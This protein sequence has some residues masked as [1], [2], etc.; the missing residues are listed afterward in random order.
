M[1]ASE[2]D[3]GG[4]IFHYE[5]SADLFRC[6]RCHAYEVVARENG[7]ITACA[8]QPP[9]GSEPIEVNAW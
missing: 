5:S 2:A 8:G 9:T 4:H 3:F 1:D 7:A 6:I